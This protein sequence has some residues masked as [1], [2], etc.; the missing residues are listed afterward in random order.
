M[1]AQV[2]GFGD[3]V[4]T[5]STAGR[6]IPFDYAFRFEGTNNELKGQPG[7]VHNSTVEISIEA[8]FTAV[9]IGYGVIPKV[10]AITF[11]LLPV[12]EGTI[13]NRTIA[14][15]ILSLTEALDEL[16]FVN[17]IGK[18]GP[19]TAAVL[20][21]GLRLNPQFADRLLTGGFEGD[22]Q[23]LGQAFQAVGA[24]P[25]RV[26]FKYAL[27]DQ[28]SGREFQSE[29]I[30]NIAGLGEIL[31]GENDELYERVGSQIR[32][33]CNLA[34]GP[35]G[36]ILDV[37][38]PPAHPQ[39]RC[40][41]HEESV[42]PEE[43]LPQAS[44]AAVGFRKLL[45][46]LG[47]RRLVPLGA[48]K[49]MLASQLAHPERLRDG[50]RLPCY[51]QVFEATTRQRFE[52]LAAAIFGEA[53][54]R[55]LQLLTP[56]LAMQLELAPILPPSQASHPAPRSPGMLLPG[57]R[58][59][60]LLV[61]SD[62]TADRAVAQNTPATSGV[63][64]GR[65]L[66]T[67]IPERLARP[68]EFQIG[69]EEALYD[70]SCASTFWGSLADRLGRLIHCLAF[71]RD[72]RKWQVLLNGRSADEQL[73]SVRPPRRGLTHPFVVTWAQHALELG[74][75]DPRNMLTEWQIFWRR[76]SA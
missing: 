4:A 63:F 13:F 30:L 43:A 47:Q 8:A 23:I 26:A 48:F 54:P 14:E 42:E 5:A 46:E 15:L 57:D 72:F 3:S 27:F 59:L 1:S 53:A 20:K 62:P 68:W 74:G 28:G 29:P 60:Y 70:L 66:R 40:V 75:Y 58:V 16:E 35:N 17:R 38:A 25:E 11:G 52:Q 61:E 76:K 18:V 55:R 64:P 39:E 37:V 9:S 33:L 24:P 71:Q 50:H 67:S 73:W 6:T 69:R 10:E 45:P 65:V 32:R 7:L 31:R 19:R 41:Q 34:A 12:S 49:Q 36:E 21:D 22:E 56:S 2:N 51:A 44:P